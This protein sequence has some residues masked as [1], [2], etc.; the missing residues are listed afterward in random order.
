M[1][2][3]AANLS[4]TPTD[5]SDKSPGMLTWKA[6]LIGADYYTVKFY[7]SD[8]LDDIASVCSLV[9]KQ[10]SLEF[11]YHTLV[12]KEAKNKPEET[13]ICA[14]VTAFKD[15]AIVGIT[16]KCHKLS[17]L[18]CNYLS[19]PTFSLFSSQFCTGSPHHTV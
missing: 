9:G 18:T 10:E 12:M 6:P 2:S 1:A 3:L 4:A 5:G 16:P 13:E 7:G 15:K 8:V 11:H 19:L 14:E 17:K